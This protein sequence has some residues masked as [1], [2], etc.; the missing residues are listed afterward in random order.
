MKLQKRNFLLLNDDGTLKIVKDILK[1][2]LGLARNLIIY[3]NENRFSELKNNLDNIKQFV[4]G[5]KRAES[6]KNEY[7]LAQFYSTM[8]AFHQFFNSSFRARQGKVLEA[9]MQEILKNYTTCNIVPRKVANMQE[10][11]KNTFSLK[12]KPKLDID[13]LGK[14]EK[15][16]KILMIQLRSRDDTGGTTEKGSLV[17]FLRALLRSKNTPKDKIM[18]L[19]AVWDERNLQQKNSTISK[20]YSSL[21]ENIKIKESEFKK[22]ISK[23]AEISKNIILKLAYGTDE[24]SESLFQW[25]DNKD[26]KILNAIKNVTQTVE[27]WDDLWVSYA[28]SS[29]EI[30]I[31][32]FKGQSNIEILDKHLKKKKIDLDNFFT[33]K[34]IDKLALQISTLWKEDSIPLPSVSDR[35]LYIRD[36]IYLKLIYNKL[37]YKK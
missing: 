4:A 27:D 25:N 16:E 34:N 6:L 28:V 20:M 13:I 31:T 5:I 30:E 22:N 2:P 29:L 15:N 21:A 36:L 3:L 1:S 33:N 23:G 19:I 18:Y 32:E 35:I 9:M 8:F 26:K 12:D 37:N 24:I 11:I 17:D 7:R 14:D 10:I